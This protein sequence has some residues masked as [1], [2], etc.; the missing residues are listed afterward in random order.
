MNLL[1]MM[2]LAVL[3]PSAEPEKADVWLRVSSNHVE[4]LTSPEHAE[5]ARKKNGAGILV[6]CKSLKINYTAEGRVIECENCVFYTS[7]GKNGTAHSAVFD[8]VKGILTL[9]GDETKPVEW[10]IS[11]ENGEH[12]IVSQSMQITLP[13]S[14][15]K[16][17]NSGDTLFDVPR[18]FASGEQLVD[19]P[20][21]TLESLGRQVDTLGPIDDSPI[22]DLFDSIDDSPIPD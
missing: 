16:R 8:Q 2:T 7:T 19:P 22:R 4:I 3:V 14:E 17:V 1:A 21:D 12:K 10:T 5:A 11:S 20:E 13:R 18:P 9:T 6:Q 15:R